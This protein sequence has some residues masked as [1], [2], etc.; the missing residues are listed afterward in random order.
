MLISILKAYE[1]TKI[2]KRLIDL[3]LVDLEDR[4]W[5]LNLAYKNYQQS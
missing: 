1:V 2:E 3:E 5:R 4:K